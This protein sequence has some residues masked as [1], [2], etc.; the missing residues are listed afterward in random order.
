MKLRGRKVL[1]TG[2][3]GFLGSHLVDRLVELG[4]ETTVIDDLS[5]GKKENLNKLAEFINLDIKDYEVLK[6]TIS[7]IKPEVVFHLAA[8]AATKENAMG[9]FNPVFDY[10]TNA[11][12][13]LNCLRA[14]IEEGLK[15]RFVYASSAAV[16]GEPEYTPIDEE[17]PTN[18]ISP[19]GISKL[20]GEKYALA[21]FREWGL[22]V[23]VLRIFNSYGPRQPRYVMFDIL[24]KLKENPDR[25]EVIG[26][27]KQL[28][29]YCYVSDTI[30]GFLLALKREAVGRVFN[31]AGKDVVSIK[32]LVNK[33]LDLLGLEERTK[34]T[35]TGESWR[36]DIIKLVADT[37]K[38]REQLGFE[39]KVQLDEGL[40]KLIEWVDGNFRLRNNN[41]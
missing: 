28:R 10:E 35:Y 14:F 4:S 20:A 40:S 32:Q 31:L 1:V 34:V 18:P 6:A 22:P 26:S 30:D 38:I 36:G 8:C 33:I 11:I 41:V 12:G 9:W 29:S 17:H 19:Y 16:Y 21:Y 5:S 3:A 7:R 37:S 24:K 27:G 2:G 25:L 13:T 39:P 23:T 15:P